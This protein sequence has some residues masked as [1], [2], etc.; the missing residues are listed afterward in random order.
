MTHFFP[1]ILFESPKVL[2]GY[3]G[4]FD[5]RGG[6]IP[7][8]RGPH[9]SPSP[10][11]RDPIWSPILLTSYPHDIKTGYFVNDMDVVRRL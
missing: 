2:S 5:R 7:R 4:H 8:G 1:K 3:I 9:P 10:H 6:G 11:A